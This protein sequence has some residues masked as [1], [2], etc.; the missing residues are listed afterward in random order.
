MLNAI[1]IPILVALISSQSSASSSLGLPMQGPAAMEVPRAFSVT[2]EPGEGIARE[3]ESEKPA[4][5]EPTTL[6]LAGA[7]LVGIALSARRWRRSVNPDG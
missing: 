3:Q 1:W 6:L 7:G 5:P 2:A 4:G